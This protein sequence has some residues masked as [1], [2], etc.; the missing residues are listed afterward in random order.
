MSPGEE[1]E[2]GTRQM[3]LEEADTPPDPCPEGDEA[4]L[5]QGETGPL[6]PGRGEGRSEGVSSVTA[7]PSSCPGGTRRQ[8]KVWSP[9]FWEHQIGVFV[10][11]R[12]LSREGP[13][14]PR[15]Q[16]PATS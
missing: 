6:L 3:L 7:S 10:K 12:R 13:A 2:L 4:P 16:R 1:I 15:R 5:E 11:D 9:V 14:R 8:R